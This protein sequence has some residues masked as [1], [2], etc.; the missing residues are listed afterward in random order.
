VKGF[1]YLS[2]CTGILRQ[3]RHHEAGLERLVQL[4]RCLMERSSSGCRPVIL[5]EA[6]DKAGALAISRAAL[7]QATHLSRWTSGLAAAST[8]A[9]VSNVA[10]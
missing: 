9:V 5:V 4:N 1:R 8:V 10:K 3:S 6:V 7:E 2:A